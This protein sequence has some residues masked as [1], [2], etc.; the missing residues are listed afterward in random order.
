MI[1]GRDNTQGRNLVNAP[2]AMVNTHS[3]KDEKI[4]WSPQLSVALF[5]LIQRGERGWRPYREKGKP[6]TA[7]HPNKPNGLVLR[8]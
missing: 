4:I 7:S 6:F 8:S 3:S 1:V 5:I 2:P